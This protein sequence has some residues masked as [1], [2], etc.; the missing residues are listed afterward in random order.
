MR[1]DRG[2]EVHEPLDDEVRG[3]LPASAVVL[4]NARCTL[5]NDGLQR[6]ARGSQGLA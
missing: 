2:V 1:A 5:T 4:T 3:D 6:H